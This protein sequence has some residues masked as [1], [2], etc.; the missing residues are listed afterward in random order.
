M[1]LDLAFRLSSI[2]LAATSFTS[3]ALALALPPWLLVLAILAFVLALLRVDPA[4]LL[5]RHLSLF[6]IS[7]MTW[8][9][10][11]VIA[12]VGFWVDL[13]LI[14]QDI[15]HAGIHF[16]ILL[17]INKL[18]NL[19]QRR[20]VLQLHARLAAEPY[21]N[22]QIHST[23]QPNI[24]SPAERVCQPCVAESP[25]RSHNVRNIQLF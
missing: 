22:V 17:L 3:L 15:L 1:K 9:V 18:S 6:R 19:D 23:R 24:L 13:L 16:L 5:S 10:F 4:S 12:F 25:S 14:S 11:L 20:D 8:N 21:N 7:P 2:L